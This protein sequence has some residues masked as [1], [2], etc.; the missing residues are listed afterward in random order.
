MVPENNSK[1]L[2]IV[3]A[4]SSVSTSLYHL[5]V[6]KKMCYEFFSK[7]KIIRVGKFVESERWEY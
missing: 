2:I 7:K 3:F 4:P 1:I 5:D 6:T